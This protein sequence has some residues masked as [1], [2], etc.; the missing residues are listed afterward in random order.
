MKIMGSIIVYSGSRTSDIRIAERCSGANFLSVCCCMIP[1]VVVA[2][3]CLLPMFDMFFYE[4]K[5]EKKVL[6]LVLV[7][8][9]NAGLYPRRT[10]P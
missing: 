7:L 6:V 4:R 10:P 5:Q 3:F 8:V 1:A 2:L 9:L